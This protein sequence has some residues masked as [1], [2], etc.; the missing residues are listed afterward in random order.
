MWDALYVLITILFFAAMLWY[1]LGCHRLGSTDRSS[2]S[3]E[4][5]RTPS[6]NR[7][8]GGGN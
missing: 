5:S 2:E 3:A 8:V 7:R 6:S 1:V 4:G